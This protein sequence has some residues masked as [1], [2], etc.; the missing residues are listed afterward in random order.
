MSVST[1]FR[2]G[3]YWYR[4]VD[5]E[6]TNPCCPDNHQECFIS[7]SISPL[8]ASCCSSRQFW[9]R[10]S[11]IDLSLS[12]R[13]LSV[14]IREQHRRH[15]GAAWRLGHDLSIESRSEWISR[16]SAHDVMNACEFIPMS[17]F[18]NNWSCPQMLAKLHQNAVSILGTH[19]WCRSLDSIDWKGCAYRWLQSSRLC[20]TE[21]RHTSLIIFRVRI[22]FD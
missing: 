16:S 5:F 19:C 6:R 3:C 22:D 1:V 20:Q 9:D 15:T 13:P 11:R 7:F 14:K 8:S 10:S 2:N 12:S 17:S 4:L 21:T 18:D